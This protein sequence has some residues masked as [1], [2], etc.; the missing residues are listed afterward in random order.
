[1]LI[2][3][4][5]FFEGILPKNFMEQTPRSTDLFQNEQQPP[6]YGMLKTLTVLTFIGCALAYLSIVVNVTQWG[7][8][9]KDL[10][11]A[12]KEAEKYHGDETM[13]AITE[14]SVEMI[15][16]SHEHRYVMAVTSLIFTTMC[17]I[18][19]MRMRKLRKSGFPF[20]V[21]G[22]L[23]PVAITAALLGFSFFGGMV[24]AITAFFAILFVILYATQR[25]Y[26]IYN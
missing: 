17:L 25:K 15:K 6:Q 3:N 1:L 18:G 5:H 23:A 21:I 12:Q 7:N 24:T 14:G 8:Y 20:Y 4:F 26:L 11:A 19:A 16:K 22:E 2:F 10:A 13:K 9:E